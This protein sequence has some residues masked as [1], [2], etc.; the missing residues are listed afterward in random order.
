M[1]D[2]AQKVTNEELLQSKAGKSAAPPPVPS[3]AVVAPEYPSFAK[4]VGNGITK[5][6]QDRR[7]LQEAEKVIHGWVLCATPEEIREARL[8]IETGKLVMESLFITFRQ[9]SGQ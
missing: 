2:Q 7:N 6:M 3:H 5:C 4:I 8:Q 1:A 9:M